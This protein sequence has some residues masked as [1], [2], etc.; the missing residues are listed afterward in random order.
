MCAHR[1]RRQ[2]CLLTAATPLKCA[3]NCS[4]PDIPQ[5]HCIVAVFSRDQ[6]SARTEGNKSTNWLPCPCKNPCQLSIRDI[7]LP[8]SIIV[9]SAFRYQ[10]IAIWAKANTGHVQPVCPSSVFNHWPV[11]ISHSRIVWSLIPVANVCPSRLKARSCTAGRRVD[12]ARFFPSCGI[13][14]VNPDGAGTASF[15]PSGDQTTR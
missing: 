13:V 12:K 3:H 6:V 15:F 4:D 8:Y 1:G 10:C 9:V 5:L 14:Q 11:L 7:P 2:G